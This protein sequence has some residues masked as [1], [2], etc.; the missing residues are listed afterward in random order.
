MGSG[1]RGGLGVGEWEVHTMR[2]KISSRMDS[3]T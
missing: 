1:S 3:A 2:F